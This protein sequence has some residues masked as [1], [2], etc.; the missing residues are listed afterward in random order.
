MKSNIVILNVCRYTKDGKDK[1][2]IS[3]FF[4]NEENLRLTDKFKGYSDLKLFYDNTN[5][6]DKLPVDVIGK[7][8]SATIE[9][10]S[11]TF[12]PLRKSS[13]ITCIEYK[14]IKYDLL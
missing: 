2:L 1:S 7:V 5:A 6:F 8:V 14:G 10:K 11:S 9:D 12:N 4:A 13:V 3:F